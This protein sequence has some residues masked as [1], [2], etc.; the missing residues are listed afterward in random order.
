MQAFETLGLNWTGFIW[1]LLNFAILFFIL[2]RFLFPPVLRM[3]DERQ[4]RIRE[5]ME[6][7]ETL[8]QESARAAEAVK[9]QLDEATWSKLFVDVTPED[10]AKKGKPFPITSYFNDILEAYERHVQ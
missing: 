1:H 2:Y 3:L 6:R 5:S 8:R 10:L 7:A 4:Q 9:A